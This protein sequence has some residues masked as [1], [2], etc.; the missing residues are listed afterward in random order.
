MKRG[1]AQRGFTLVEIMIAVVIIGLLAVIAVPTFAKLRTRSVATR[2]INDIRQY[3]D[4]YQRYSLEN[5]AWPPVGGVSEMPTGMELLLPKAYEQPSPVG[6]GFTWSGDSARMRLTNATGAT[7][8]IMILVDQG[9]DDGDLSGGDF[10]RAGSD[11][12]L[13]LR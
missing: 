2:L 11:F 6:G 7:E 9:V 10:R 13:Q 4:A 8:T 3:S 12:V 1:P 5:G